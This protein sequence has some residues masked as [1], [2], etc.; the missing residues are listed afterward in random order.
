MNMMKVTRAAAVVMVSTLASSPPAD[1]RREAPGTTPS[2]DA[3]IRRIAEA[4]AW[5][6]LCVNYSVDPDAVAKFRRREH[7]AVDGHYRVVYGFA[8]ARN[9]HEAMGMHGGN[10]VQSCFRALDRFGTDG[11]NIPGLVRSL[12]YGSVPGQTIDLDGPGFTFFP[13]VK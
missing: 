11:Q 9:H 10:I 5:S 1:A 12:W 13:H 7:I 2:K 4:T 3:L 6:E 8:Y